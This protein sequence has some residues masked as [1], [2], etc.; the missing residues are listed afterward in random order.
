EDLDLSAGLRVLEIGAGTGYNA[1][2]LAHV[3]GEVVSIDVDREVLEDARR[4]LESFP[5]RRVALCHADGRLGWPAGAP[6]DRIQVTAASED[7]EPAWLEQLT[8]GG[9][10]Q[11]PIDLAPGLAWIVQGSVHGGAFAGELTRAAYFMPLRDEGDPG[12]DRSVSTGPL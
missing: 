4:H 7:L 5:N 1:A 11:A 2:L 3:V 9:I 8:R 12:R 10:V 6:Y